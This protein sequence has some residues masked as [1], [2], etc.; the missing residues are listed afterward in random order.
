VKAKLIATCTVLLSSCL[1][2]QIS[3]NID[4]IQ[5]S[6]FAIETI[7]SN[8]ETPWSVAELPDQ[9]YLITQRDGAL[10]FVSRT[11]SF[12]INGLPDDIYVSGQGGLLDVALAPDFKQ[13]REIYISYSY[14]KKD[15]NGTALLRAKY[16]KDKLIDSTVI[17]RASPPKAAA[18]HFGGKI[19]FL[20]DDTLLLTLGDGFAY[21]EA[22]Q[23]KNSL[24]GK[25]V[26]LMRDGG[27]P[28][29]NPYL[30]QD[31]TKP[32]IFSMGHRNVQGIT[33]DTQT[34]TIWEHEHGPRGGDELNLIEPGRNYGWPI[35]SHGLDYNGAKITP[36]KSYDEMVDPKHVWVP[37]IAPSGL[38]IY[39]G[40]LFPQWNGSAI[41][42]GLASGDVRIISFNKNSSVG[43]MKILNDLDVRIRDIRV[44]KEGAILILTD[45]P[46]NG[47]L[48]RMT[49]K[50]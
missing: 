47:S 19:Q 31:N 21:R 16:E 26:R 48:L 41:I 37:S 43:E 6:E 40:N 3:P 33:Y 27:V 18:S 23:D 20:P 32:Q 46:E 34:N 39:R 9:G 10:L 11:K 22:A 1:E 8:L 12:Q 25:I 13:S 15:S 29:D 42:G 5:S 17:F 50:K 4:S 14:G 45:D 30:G 7:T 24:L 44:D 38:V 36:F 35:A 49:P 28:S 2:T